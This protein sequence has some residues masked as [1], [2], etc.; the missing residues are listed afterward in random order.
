MLGSMDKRS[1]E[2]P[3][4]RRVALHACCGP[5]LIEPF[6]AYV[7]PEVEVTVVFCN[8]NI[9]PADEYERRRETLL[10]YA[11]QQGIDIAELPYDPASWREATRAAQSTAQRCEACYALRLDEVAKWAKANGFDAL[12]TTLTV[13]PYQDAEAIG[14]AGTAAAQR[15][16]IEYLHSDFTER[17]PEA[18]RRSREEGMYRQNYCG[19]LPSKA[20]AQAQR[21]HRKAQRRANKGTRD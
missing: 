14:R 20:E 17:Y 7:S 11:T 5:C 21:E 19:C 18:T 3:T 16:G 2:T 1:H 10:G 6:D 8:S 13:S 12:G 4:P 15:H 9:Q